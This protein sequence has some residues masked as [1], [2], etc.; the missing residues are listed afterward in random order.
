VKENTKHYHLLKQRRHKRVRSKVKGTT[1]CPRLSVF[2]SHSHIYAQV[3]DDGL[4]YT[5][6]SSSDLELSPRKPKEGKRLTKTEQAQEVGKL[7]AQKA[8]EKG[9]KK[10]VFDRGGNKYH[11][12][13]KAL[14]EAARAAGLQ[15]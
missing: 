5:L 1:A 12:R 3:I 6:V 13:L 11:G 8:Q 2:R 4:G 15:F 9:I 10:V 7:I 14:A